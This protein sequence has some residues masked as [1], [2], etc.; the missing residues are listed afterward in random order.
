MNLFPTR[1]FIP[2][3]KLGSTSTL[4]SID[5]PNDDSNDL[6]KG[7]FLCI[8]RANDLSQEGGFIPAPQVGTHNDEKF[9]T[10]HA[11]DASGLFETIG[12]NLNLFSSAMKVNS[13]YMHILHF[14]IIINGSMH[15]NDLK[16]K[17]N[18]NPLVAMTTKNMT[19]S[20]FSSVWK[21]CGVEIIWS[22]S[23]SAT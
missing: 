4:R 9:G 13:Q 20:V 1:S 7:D 17:L 15:I 12:E 14:K 23:A 5:F 2:P 18:K 21:V 6:V 19:S 22:F 10:H 3:I 11:K 8:R 16:D